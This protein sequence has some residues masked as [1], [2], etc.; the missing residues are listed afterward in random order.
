MLVLL[1]ITILMVM[2]TGTMGAFASFIISSKIHNF[3]SL[4]NQMAMFN[5]DTTLP[6]SQ[7]SWVYDFR[8]IE[9]GLLWLMR[10]L[11]EYKTYIPAA[12][13]ATLE[14]D[15]TPIKSYE[16]SIM[17][18]QV[19]PSDLKKRNSTLSLA[20]IDM[21]LMQQK[22]TMVQ[23]KLKNFKSL[24]KRVPVQEM[25]T[26][27][28]DVVDLVLQTSNLRKGNIERLECNKSMYFFCV[29]CITF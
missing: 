5:F 14:Q 27:Y 20:K 19:A 7:L 3:A 12:V 10:R 21:S 8:K 24:L 4:M 15:L 6:Q 23:I 26:M 25:V 16:E 11:K 1:A 13:L 18:A 9:L 28:G 22:V 2:L 17:Q 29:S